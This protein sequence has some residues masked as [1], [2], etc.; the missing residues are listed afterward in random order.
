MNQIA[1]LLTFFLVNTCFSQLLKSEYSWESRHTMGGLSDWEV[2]HIKY[3]KDIYLSISDPNSLIMD[4]N[5]CQIHVTKSLPDSKEIPYA[6]YFYSQSGFLDSLFSDISVFFVNDSLDV[7]YNVK[8]T[9]IYQDSTL[10]PIDRKVV[11]VPLHKNYFDVADLTK[12]VTNTNF[13]YSDDGKLQ[14]CTITMNATGQYGPV[15]TEILYFDENCF[16]QSIELTCNNES[17]Y[18]LKFKYIQCSD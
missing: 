5:I 14:K 17:I 1:T 4:N 9:I 15:C 6:F 7:H 10:F 8:E 2:I 12:N 11:K 13:E 18:D 3:C 16:V